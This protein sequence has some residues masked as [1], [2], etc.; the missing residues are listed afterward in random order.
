MKPI[1]M[2]EVLMRMRV[3]TEQA[4]AKGIEIPNG[5]N[6]TDFSAILKN[7]IAQVNEMQSQAKTLTESFER[8]DANVD[9]AQVMIATQ[10]A[11]LAFQAM[12][13]VRNKLVSA[14]QEVMNM[15]I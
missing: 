5:N 12:S 1:D 2:N 11:S 8:G 7:S 15:P 6:S 14:Y 9:I 10:K 4:Q 13:Q 3:L